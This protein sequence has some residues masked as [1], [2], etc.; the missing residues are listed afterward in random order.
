M[1]FSDAAE[2]YLGD[3]KPFRRLA[4]FGAQ[5]EFDVAHVQDIATQDRRVELGGQINTLRRSCTHHARDIF[6]PPEWVARVHPFGTVRKM[7]VIAGIQFRQF[8][9]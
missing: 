3:M 1:H 6:R 5:A 4:E 2:R 8:F 7:K 9:E